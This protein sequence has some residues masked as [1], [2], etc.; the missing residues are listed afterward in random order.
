MALEAE[1]DSAAD[2]LS[3]TE[4]L[5]HLPGVPGGSG[6]IRSQLL[7][8]VSLGFIELAW[9]GESAQL[10]KRKNGELSCSQLPAVDEKGKQA[11]F[12]A[13]NWLHKQA[14]QTT[15]TKATDHS[16][17]RSHTRPTLPRHL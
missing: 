15:T 3:N 13:W 17:S 7:L 14:G 6:P 11:M 9:R 2:S 5:I 10:E 12:V 16:H 1:T 8:Q 4:L